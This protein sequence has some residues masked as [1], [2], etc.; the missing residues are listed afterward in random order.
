MVGRFVWSERLGVL[1]GSHLEYLYRLAGKV[2]HRKPYSHTI[3]NEVAYTYYIYYMCTEGIYLFIE[4]ID[5]EYSLIKCALPMQLYMRRH[6]CCIPIFWTR[7]R[8]KTSFLGVL[9]P[10]LIGMVSLAKQQ[11]QPFEEEEKKD[12]A[13]RNLYM[14][15]VFFFCG[16]FTFALAPANIQFWL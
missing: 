8:K 12:E 4:D 10:Q 1:A 3:F 15:R 7:R 13:N 14:L 9:N 16:C 11:H 6:F 5:K 2:R